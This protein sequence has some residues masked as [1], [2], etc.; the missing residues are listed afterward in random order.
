M[1]VEHDK[2]PQPQTLLQ[3]KL[4]QTMNSENN[5]LMSDNKNEERSWNADNMIWIAASLQCLV[6]ELVQDDN[7]SKSDS[8]SFQ[9]KFVAMPVLL[10]LATEIAL[11]AWQC[12]ERQEKPDHDHDLLRLFEG[13]REDTQAWLEAKLPEIPDPLLGSEFP[14]IHPGIRVTLSSNRNLFEK[15][16][17]LYESRGGKRAETGLL[18]EALTVLID[19]YDESAKS[20]FNDKT[21]NE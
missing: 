16:R 6:K 21:P 7:L 3:E 10:A 15:W 12:R 17:Y 9:G 19:A 18:N 11:K 5:A 1:R 14:P 2:I 8:L 13:L 20:F 4:D